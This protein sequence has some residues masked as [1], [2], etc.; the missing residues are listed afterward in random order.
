MGLDVG[1]LQ[2]IYSL[3]LIVNGLH[4]YHGHLLLFHQTNQ[5]L[6]VNLDLALDMSHVIFEFLRFFNFAFKVAHVL[7]D[8]MDLIKYDFENL[9]IFGQF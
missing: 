4:R 8:A 9:A 3:Y 5:N 2:T 7:L 6:V 1:L